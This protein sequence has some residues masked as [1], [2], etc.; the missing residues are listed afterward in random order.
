MS[1]SKR[2]RRT[3]AII[4]A[5]L[6][7]PL[8]AFPA[9]AHAATGTFFY[10]S[11]E[12]GDLEINNPDDGECRLLLQGADRARNAT[13]ATA[14]LFSDRGCEDTHSTLRPGQS[15]TFTPPNLPHSVIFHR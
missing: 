9:D 15:R 11:P 5:A 4:A 1:H 14:T 8:G 13:N 7:L 2:L 6:T 10:H 12:S 3:T